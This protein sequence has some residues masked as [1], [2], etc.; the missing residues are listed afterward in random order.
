MVAGTRGLTHLD[1]A[2]DPVEPEDPLVLAAMVVARDVPTPAME[3]EPVRVDRP[4]LASV[5]ERDRAARTRPRRRASRAGRRRVSGRRSRWCRSALVPGHAAELPQPLCPLDPFEAHRGRGEVQRGELVGI[6]PGIADVV[7]VLR[8]AVARAGAGRNA[9]RSTITMG[10]PIS[11][12]A[13]LSRSNARGETPSDRPGNRRSAVAISSAV[14]GLEVSRSAAV[15]FNRRSSLSVDAMVRPYFRPQTATPRF[16]TV[17]GV[18][19]D[20]ATSAAPSA[21]MPRPRR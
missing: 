11:R 4:R 2:V 6:E 13:S 10:M 5:F 7:L 15:R 18:A 8:D 17:N 9:A 19:T 3:V 14:S 12:S 16:V 1:V 21:E 20:A